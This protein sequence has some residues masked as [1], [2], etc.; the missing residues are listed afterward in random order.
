M[1]NNLLSDYNDLNRKYIS[2][3]SMLV[4]SCILI[5]IFVL[6]SVLFILVPD[7]SPKYRSLKA[8]QES[9][10]SELYS[11]QQECSRLQSELA[12][13][14][15]A[16]SAAESIISDISSV[17]PPQPEPVVYEDAYDDGFS[18]GW[19]DG[20]NSAYS[21]GFLQGKA[22]GNSYSSY[23]MSSGEHLR[24]EYAS[25][26]EKYYSIWFSKASPPNSD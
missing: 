18:D 22:D 7:F 19:S 5:V 17:D 16:L 24:S 25:I 1:S 3:K 2:A 6:I 13:S 4:V 26:I 11:A 8:Q 21:A 15:E 10:L 23:F 9:T 12:S 14:N 20:A